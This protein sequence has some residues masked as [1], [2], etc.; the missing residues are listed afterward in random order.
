MDIGKD[1]YRNGKQMKILLYMKRNRAPANR[2]QTGIEMIALQNSIEIVRTI[3][4]L[5]RSFMQPE[6]KPAITIIMVT[7]KNELLEIISM[8]HLLNDTKIILI[9]PDDRK[10]IF[11]LGCKL[12]PRFVS[13][14]G[15]DFKDVSAVV[16][17]MMTNLGETTTKKRRA[18]IARG[19]IMQP[20]RDE[21][22]KQIIRSNAGK[23]SIILL[24]K[25]K[26]VKRDDGISRHNGPGGKVDA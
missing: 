1:K 14:T 24:K 2:L 5:P 11:T 17:K 6:N 16:E 13:Y 18:S 8:Q 23:K 3:E 19:Y 9:L 20:D 26:V 21:R 4:D 22:R 25:R 12:Y 7:N 10:D 15:S